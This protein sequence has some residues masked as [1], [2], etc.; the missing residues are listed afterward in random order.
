MLCEVFCESLSFNKLWIHFFPHKTS[1]NPIFFNILNRLPPHLLHCLCR[2]IAALLPPVDQWNSVKATSPVCVCMRVLVHKINKTSRFKFLPRFF[3]YTA[4]RI[5]I[6]RAYSVTLLHVSS[7]LTAT[8]SQSEWFMFFL[9]YTYLQSFSPPAKLLRRLRTVRWVCIF[10]V[11]SVRILR[12]T[13]S[14]TILQGRRVW[15]S[16]SL[17]VFVESVWDVG[18][19]WWSQFVVWQISFSQGR[20]S[21][22]KQFDLVLSSWFLRLTVQLVM[23]TSW[24]MTAVFCHNK[25]TNFYF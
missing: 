12:P 4:A 5:L 23:N 9:L 16:S 1:A 24:K 21:L 7:S 19:T 15:R 8:Q 6:K 18:S 17:S 2:C 20:F 3:N 13:S 25:A 14:V 11:L 22:L 10:S